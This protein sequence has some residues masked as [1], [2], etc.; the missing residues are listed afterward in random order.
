[1]FSLV[2]LLYT[3]L[4]QF[5]FST[6]VD[7][8]LNIKLRPFVFTKS[9]KK[10][11]PAS[12]SESVESKR[13]FD[14]PYIT[15]SP[16]NKQTVAEVHGTPDESRQKE[17]TREVQNLMRWSYGTPHWGETKVTD[18]GPFVTDSLFTGETHG[19][20]YSTC[21]ENDQSDK[22]IFVE[23]TQEGVHGS[24]RPGLEIPVVELA[25]KSQLELGPYISSKAAGENLAKYAQPVEPEAARLM[26]TK[27]FNFRGVEKNE[28]SQR[29]D[30]EKARGQDPGKPEETYPIIRHL[31]E[32]YK[33]LAVVMRLAAMNLDDPHETCSETSLNDHLV[34]CNTDG[35]EGGGDPGSFPPE[36]V[37]QLNP[38]PPPQPTDHFAIAIQGEIDPRSV[39]DKH[40]QQSQDRPES[41]CEYMYRFGPASAGAG[42][43]NLFMHNGE[44]AKTSD[45]PN[46]EFSPYDTLVCTPKK[47]ALDGSRTVLLPIGHPAVPSQSQTKATTE[48]VSDYYLDIAVAESLPHDSSNDSFSVSDDS[49]LF[50]GSTKDELEK[51]QMEVKDHL[52]Q[53]ERQGLLVSRWGDDSRIKKKKIDRLNEE[54]EASNLAGDQGPLNYSYE[55]GCEEEEGSD[56]DER[57]EV[58]EFEYVDDCEDS[59]DDDGEIDQEMDKILAWIALEDAK[60]EAT[61]QSSKAMVKFDKSRIE[62]LVDT[63][64]DD[65]EGTEEIVVATRLVVEKE[66]S[67]VDE[68]ESEDDDGAEL[69]EENEYEEGRKVEEENKMGEVGSD[70]KDEYGKVEADN[71]GMEME[72]TIMGTKEDNME[73]RDETRD[74]KVEKVG[75]KVA[76]E[77][78]DHSVRAEESKE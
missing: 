2:I 1:M 9:E 60:A 10:P 6:R 76:E 69:E 31:I 19:T 46:V 32:N 4:L 17:I 34:E 47:V 25:T 54:D 27:Q 53:A 23:A 16:E 8:F 55:K 40:I 70:E 59:G 37:L 75:V 12:H 26:D 67:V 57:I 14:E 66:L 78:S 11:D 62:E 64:G 52:E 74:T 24:L 44:T 68:E 35:T 3:S 20:V 58:F 22:S 72:E 7:Y 71:K 39:V 5:D 61:M 56:H 51:L 73:V 15:K 63:D 42:T 36:P 45:L 33:A 48:S 21:M 38:P 30:I 49:Y 41:D 77:K 50:S 28:N 13:L 29:V 18:A 65:E 43:V